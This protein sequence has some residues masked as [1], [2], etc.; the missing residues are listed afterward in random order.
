MLAELS[1]DAARAALT[2][3]KQGRFKPFHDALYAAGPSATRPSA[4]PRGRPA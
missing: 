2:A 3:A 4:R 1:R